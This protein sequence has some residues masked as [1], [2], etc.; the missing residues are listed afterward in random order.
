M[1]VQSGRRGSFVESRSLRGIF[2][3]LREVS[4]LP[5][6]PGLDP[7]AVQSGRHTR[8]VEFRSLARNI[9]SP[10]WPTVSAERVLY[11]FGRIILFLRNSPL[12][13]KQSAVGW[14]QGLLRTD[15]GGAAPPFRPSLFPCLARIF[16]S[17]NLAPPARLSP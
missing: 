4:V 3:F 1:A 6:S 7:V 2:R 14:L 11:S 10:I 5:L 17:L 15:P 13:N 9:C 16:F 12:R 8:P